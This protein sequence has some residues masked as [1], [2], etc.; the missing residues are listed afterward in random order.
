MQ[1]VEPPFT[2]KE[3]ASVFPIDMPIN[4]VL[5]DSYDDA[6]DET[7]PFRGLTWDRVTP[8]ML[9]KNFE[10][11]WFFSP[12]AMHY[13]LPAFM[14]CTMSGIGKMDLPLDYLLSAMSMKDNPPLVEWGKSRWEQLSAEQW[15]IITKWLLWLKTLPESGDFLNLE[16]ASDAVKTGVWLNK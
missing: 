2:F 14:R 10:V 11:P 9:R 6:V 13:F 15:A 12:V 1:K 4:L 8:E 5:T 3:L 7:E 16:S